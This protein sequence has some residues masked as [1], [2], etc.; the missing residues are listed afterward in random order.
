MLWRNLTNLWYAFRDFV[1]N[2]W[3]AF[4]GLFHYATHF[5]RQEKLKKER[6][7]HHYFREE[8][9]KKLFKW[10]TKERRKIDRM[11]QKIPKAD[12]YNECM[13]NYIASVLLSVH[14][15]Q[16]IQQVLSTFYNYLHPYLWMYLH[17]FRD[18]KQILDSDNPSAHLQPK[19]EALRKK[20]EGVEDLKARSLQILGVHKKITRETKERAT[21]YKRQK[22]RQ[23]ASFDREMLKVEEE[24]LSKGIEKDKEAL[25]GLQEARKQ[26]EQINY[27]PNTK[28]RR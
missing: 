5:Q 19:L 7:E 21:E 12:R 25:E 17:A 24:I 18:L 22:H 26:Q 4:I 1:K 20:Y 10:I 8:Q 27:S 23:T 2:L 6:D 13:Y 14:P 11:K 28:R 15:K 16:T 3:Q 9:K